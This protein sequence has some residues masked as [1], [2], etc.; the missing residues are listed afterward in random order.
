[1]AVFVPN[2]DLRLGSRV[3]TDASAGKNYL[4][5]TGEVYNRGY[6][7]AYNTT[8]T[9]KL[10]VVKPFGTNNTELIETQ[11]PLGDIQPCDF[12]SVRNSF[13]C[14]YS[15]EKWEITGN[16]SAAK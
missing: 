9:V 1:M 13:Y 5:V 2:L 11:W 16:C 8:L 7:T 3:L 10:W 14:P 12:F 15:I 4:W 6:G